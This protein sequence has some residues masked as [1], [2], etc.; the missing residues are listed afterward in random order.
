MHTTIA[1]FLALMGVP[2]VAQQSGTTAVEN[3]WQTYA[4]IALAVAVLVAIVLVLIR[5]QHRKFNE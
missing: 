5:K 3:P 4:Y 2:A 1:F